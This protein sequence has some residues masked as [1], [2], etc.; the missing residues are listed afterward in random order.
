MKLTLGQSSVGLERDQ[1][2][3][4]RDAIGVRVSC[5]DGALWITQEKVAADVLLEAGQSFV[6]DTAGLTLVTALH[7]STL[8]L[9]ERPSRLSALWQALAGW[10][11]VGPLGRSGVY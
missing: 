2:I 4:M 1:S 8:R 5:L 10:L 6:I 3:A 7:P 11:R 9:R